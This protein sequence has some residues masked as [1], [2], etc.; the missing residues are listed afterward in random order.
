[1]LTTALQ[2]GGGKD[3][4]AVLEVMRPELDEILVVWL[5][6]GAAFPET[7]DLMARV[8][9]EV[10]HF[11]EVRTD[12]L[13]DIA[14][15]GWPVDVL[16]V[17]QS[18]IGKACMSTQGPLLRGWNECCAANFWR[19]LHNAM[20]ERGITRIIRGQRNSEAYKSPVRDGMT[21][22]G[23]EYVFPLQGWSE[24]EV[25]AFLKARGVE[26]PAYYAHTKSSLDCWNCTAF[27]DVKDNQLNYMRDH[28]P[29]K[30]AV[31]H[32]KLREIAAVTAEA[33]RPMAGLI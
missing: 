1:M 22:D 15:H 8:S 31:V 26:I 9:A 24:D 14:E 4:L 32:G 25:F 16:P 6:T 13:S 33:L 20:V 3:S 12:V 28:H 2:F 17:A 19:P 5:N 11:L 7:L 23:I 30:Y 10:P 27:L 29:D 18:A 21:L